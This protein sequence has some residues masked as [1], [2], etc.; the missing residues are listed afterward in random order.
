MHDTLTSRLTPYYR[1]TSY[2]HTVYISSLVQQEE[3]N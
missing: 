3:L 2:L 1:D